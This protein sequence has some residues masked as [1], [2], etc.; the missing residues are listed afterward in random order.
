MAGLVHESASW[1]LRVRAAEA[2]GRLGAGA[3]PSEPIVETLAAA[4]RGDSFAL[5][6]EAAAHALAA[7]DGPEA[8][9]VLGE[10]AHNDAEPRVRE[11][12]AELLTRK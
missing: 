5:V 6:R 11:A 1:P 4:A 3:R 8:R 9:R 7:I 2:L 12:A 10:L